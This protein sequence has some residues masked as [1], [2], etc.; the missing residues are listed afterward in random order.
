MHITFDFNIGK[1]KNQGI[2]QN[3]SFFQQ[4]SPRSS[5]ENLQ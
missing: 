1:E 5:A 4:N 2:F 3:I